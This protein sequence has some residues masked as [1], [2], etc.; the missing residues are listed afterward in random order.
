MAIFRLGERWA[1]APALERLH[2]ERSDRSPLDGDA[3]RS[4]PLEHHH[5]GAAQLEL[6]REQEPDRAGAYDHDVDLLVHQL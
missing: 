5:T 3:W 6:D 4:E 2:A 1:H